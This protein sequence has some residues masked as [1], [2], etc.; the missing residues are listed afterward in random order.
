MPP[1]QKQESIQKV[2]SSRADAWKFVHACDEDGVPAGY[3][4]RPKGKEY[5]AVKYLGK[6]IK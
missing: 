6:K 5:W 2:F 4:Y 3:P 1:K